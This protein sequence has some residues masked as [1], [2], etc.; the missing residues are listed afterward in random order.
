MIPESISDKIKIDYLLRTQSL[1][2]AISTFVM[3]NLSSSLIPS[4][5]PC[6]AVLSCG[7]K[8]AP[9]H[10]NKLLSSLPLPVSSYSILISP[11]FNEFSVEQDAQAMIDQLILLLSEQSADHSSSPPLIL[12]IGHSRGGAAATLAASILTHSKAYKAIKPSSV[13]TLLIDPVDSA[14]HISTSSILPSTVEVPP[15]TPYLTSH[16]PLSSQHR[17][18]GKAIITT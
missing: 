16:R 7:Y 9:F 1:T 18:V 4:T 10:Y 13:L 8:I 3:S 5:L 2:R 17:M 14:D 12:L 11:V 15:P 6:V